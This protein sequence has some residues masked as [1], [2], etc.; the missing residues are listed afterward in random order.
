MAKVG[1]FSESE[2]FQNSAEI[3]E[4]AIF[5]V[6][7]HNKKSNSAMEFSRVV[8]AEKQVVAGTIYK[9]TIEVSEGGEK[10]LYEAS[11]W[12]KPWE[13]FKELQQFKKVE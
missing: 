6:T 1:G 11:V 10:E 5:A 2:G 9:L 8:K 12:V 13:N 4:L 3:D 7:E